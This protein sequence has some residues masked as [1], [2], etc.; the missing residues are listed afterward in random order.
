MTEVAADDET[1]RPLSA[2]NDLVTMPDGSVYLTDPGH[3]P[4]PPEP[5]GRLLRLRSDGRVENVNGPFEYCNGVARDH[6]DRILLVEANGLLRI[7]PDG[8][9]TWLVE[10]FG[11]VA[12]DGMAVDVEGSVYVCCPGDHRIRVVSPEGTIESSIDFA[13]GS[14]PTNC[15]FGGPNGNDLFVTLAGAKTVVAVE[16][17]PHPGVP[18]IAWPGLDAAR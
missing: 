16:G 3:H 18:V 9:S 2:P 10:D 13:D 4:L 11:G 1:G 6:R 7:E 12:G 5:A 17:L 14:L 8:R 15:C